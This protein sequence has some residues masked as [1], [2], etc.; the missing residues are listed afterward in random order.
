MPSKPTKNGEDSA[1]T[2]TIERSPFQALPEFRPPK[3]K[4]PQSSLL[5]KAGR[6]KPA[7][8][9]SIWVRT[10]KLQGRFWRPIYEGCAQ[11]LKEPSTRSTTP[12]IALKGSHDRQDRLAPGHQAAMP[13]LRRQVLRL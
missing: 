13:D 8:T 11:F 12:R 9:F 10:T 1:V 6:A 3:R 5:N 7:P 4:A 2:R